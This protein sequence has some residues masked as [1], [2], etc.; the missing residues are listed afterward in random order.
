MTLSWF[1]RKPAVSPATPPA[2]ASD[3]TVAASDAELLAQSL[4]K[5]LSNEILQAL[6]PAQTQVQ[7]LRQL[8][9]TLTER[10]QPVFDSIERVHDIAKSAQL[11]SDS[12][13]LGPAAET[14]D[15]ANIARAAILGRSDWLQARHINVR[16]ALSGAQVQARPGE[17]YTFIDELLLWASD[18]SHNVVVQLDAVGG[19]GGKPRA[20]LRVGAW[21]ESNDHDGV[22]P[23]WQ[24]TRWF[25]WHRIARRL[26][27]RTELRIE[28][29]HI[30]LRV[31][32]PPPTE[33]MPTAKPSAHSS[34][35]PIHSQLKGVRVLLISSHANR[36]SAVLDA[37]VPQGVQCDVAISVA[38]ARPLLNGPT[39]DAVIYD[40]DMTPEGVLAM[41]QAPS[42]RMSTA[43]V[44]IHA[45]GTQRDFQ[46]STVG[47]FTTG[48]VAADAISRALVPALN[49]E[50]F[51]GIG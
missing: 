28:D 35:T 17:L 13:D 32:F 42:I 15:A 11:F 48:H 22:N 2:V 37:L 44:E 23:K 4:V 31:S 7:Q 36:R 30:V 43:F 1:N 39:L 25:V 20:R 33:A 3:K 18:F 24:N 49:F 16:Q 50:L 21:F 45:N 51:K 19:D 29:D 34:S 14:L 46:A 26:G 27:A 47:A 5:Q 40:D 8:S 10:M 12:P 41:R 38:G 6:A 9:S